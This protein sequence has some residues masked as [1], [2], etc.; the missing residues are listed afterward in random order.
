MVMDLGGAVAAAA[1]DQNTRVIV[2]T[3]RG[4]AF[5]AGADVA[6]FTETGRLSDALARESLDERLRRHFNPAMLQ[7]ALAAKPVIAALNGVAAG[8]GMSVALACD[9][10]LAARSARFVAAFGQV[11]LAPDCGATYFF[12]KVLG[13]SLALDMTLT[14]RTLSAEE[15]AALG[16]V[17]R[18]VDDTELAKVAD[19]LAQAL[20]RGPALAQ[21]LAKRAFNAVLEPALTDALEREAEI[22]GTLSRSADHEEGVRA[23][24]DRRTARFGP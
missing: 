17:H 24:L 12:P 7:I 20:A 23:F 13:H 2:I 1:T 21:S 5:C 6:T 11:G 16:V 4:R 18:V 15:A 22:Q 8:M 9:I 19:D 14:G 10:R 3:G